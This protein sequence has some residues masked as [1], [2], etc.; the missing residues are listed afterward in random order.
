MMQ[1]VFN[2]GTNTEQS[3]DVNICQEVVKHTDWE[4][5][6]LVIKKIFTA[7]ETVVPVQTYFSI[8]LNDNYQINSVSLYKNNQL[9]MRFLQYHQVIEMD[10]LF[11]D[12]PNQPYHQIITLEL[13]GD[14]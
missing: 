4:F 5:S 9:L 1:I 12:I 11:G 14:E 10:T 13:K 7:E 2:E 8:I 6:R 3:Y